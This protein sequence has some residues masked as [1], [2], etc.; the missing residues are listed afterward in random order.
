MLSIGRMSV[1]PAANAG[2]PE[3]GSCGAAVVK[4]SVFIIGYS[5][6]GRGITAQY[7]R[8][9]DFGFVPSLLEKMKPSPFQCENRP[10]PYFEISECSLC[11]GPRSRSFS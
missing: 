2:W 3:P 10:W 5:A 6:G 1:K 8:P 9:L 7:V 11:A 4:R